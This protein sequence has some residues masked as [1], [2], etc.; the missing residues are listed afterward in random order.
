MLLVYGRGSRFDLEF[1][2][3]ICDENHK[4][5]FIFGVFYV[6]S[7]WQVGNSTE[8][9]LTYKIYIVKSKHDIITL[10]IEH[11]IVEMELI[12]TGIIPIIN[13]YWENNFRIG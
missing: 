9:N 3:H 5:T 1:L 4:Q 13:K 6:T 10:R 11:M 7:L 8:H 2:L 12:L